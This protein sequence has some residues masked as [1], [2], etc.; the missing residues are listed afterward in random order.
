[1]KKRAPIPSPTPEHERAAHSAAVTLK[2]SVITASDTRALAEDASGDLL[3]RGLAAAGLV[4]CDRRIVRDEIAALSAAVEGA[5]AAG[6]DVVVITGGTGVAPRD[7]TPEA[8]V[9]LGVRVLPGFGEAFRALSIARVGPA[10]L[11]SRA[12]AGTLERAVV[13]ALPGSP[14]ACDLA[15]TQ[16]ILPGV[17]H[18]LHHLR[19]GPAKGAPGGRTAP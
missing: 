2:A 19:G 1:M 12:L 16:L 7:V 17:R 3:V 18:L 14:D 5:L 11:L 8:L 10:A 13:Y 9:A 6:A 15:L 4:V